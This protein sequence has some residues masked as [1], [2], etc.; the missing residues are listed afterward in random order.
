MYGQYRYNNTAPCYEE[1]SMH[2]I[3][4]FRVI[5]TFPNIKF[6]I[7][8]SELHKRHKLICDKYIFLPILPGINFTFGQGDAIHT[9]WG[10]SVIK[11]SEILGLN[12]KRLKKRMDY[13][14]LNSR[15]FTLKLL[16]SPIWESSMKEK[17]EPQVFLIAR[18][19]ISKITRR[20]TFVPKV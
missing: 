16:N 2:F 12:K 14:H 13:C 15:L 7:M 19:R 18:L 10:I 8:F 20:K 9:F 1:N 4:H 3:T 6:F 17:E 11:S 5:N